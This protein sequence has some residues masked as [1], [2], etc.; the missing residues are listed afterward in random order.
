VLQTGHAKSI[1]YL[2]QWPD[3]LLSATDVDWIL[4]DVEQKRQVRAGRG[5]VVGDGGE[6]FL[7][8]HEALFELHSGLDGSTLAT[9][10]AEASYV[11]AGIARDG[12]YFFIAGT[13]SLRAWS[14]AGELLT[15][16]AKNY[17]NGG[18]NR[19]IDAAPGELR[20][21][22]G[23]NDATRIEYI[24]VPGNTS[25]FGA[26]LESSFAGWFEDGERALGRLGNNVFV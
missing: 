9:V 15:E 14:P 25:S 23:P 16:I 17:N 22:N 7:T 11:P 24:Q 19:T 8:Q 18:G 1:A 2:A 20:V 13:K 21:G 6:Y 4:W 5:K 3:R 10:T 12:S 26:A